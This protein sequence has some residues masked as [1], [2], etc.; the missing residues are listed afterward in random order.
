[1]K[2]YLIRGASMD[3]GIRF[4]ACNTTMLVEE[5]RSIHDCYPVSIAALGRL[6]TAGCMM[7]TMLKSEKDRLTIQINGRGPAGSIVVT[8]DH[9]GNVKGYIHNPQVELMQKENGKLDVGR[10]VGV[11]GTLTVIKDL[12]LKE[13][14]MGQVPLTT[15]EVGDDLTSYFAA[16][17]QTPTAVG[18]GVFVEVDGRVSAA[19]GFILQVLPEAD[20][21]T[22]SK[23]EQNLTRLASVTDMLK[24]DRDVESIIKEI[25]GDIPYQI[26]E[27]MDIRYICD[28]SRE[29]IERALISMGEKEINDMIIEQN[30][31]EVVCHF[32]NRKYQ[33]D[34][35]DLSQM[36]EKAKA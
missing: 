10:A 30:M 35:E 12:G 26:Y 21:S 17:E 25:L 19:G 4:F 24:N 18:L 7:G 29:R 3:G 14:Y 27:N 9:T 34:K 5:A 16:S 33:F 15:G 20:D 1:M 11:D 2:D 28:C 13:P 36:L 22:V 31:A 23:I 8:S 32:C 6:L